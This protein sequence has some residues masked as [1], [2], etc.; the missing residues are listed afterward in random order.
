MFYFLLSLALATQQP[1]DGSNPGVVGMQPEVPGVAEMVPPVVPQIRP[2]LPDLGD[3]GDRVGYWVL[4]VYTVNTDYGVRIS[5][6]LRDSAAWRAGIEEN[7]IIVTV[8][9]YQIGVVDGKI[10]ELRD[11]IQRRVSSNVYPSV[12]PSVSLVVWDHRTGKLVNKTV[13]LDYNRYRQR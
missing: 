7:D 12:K 1:V 8:G 6:V 9:G 2:D 13:V 5:G 3:R 10:Y 4:G 11:E